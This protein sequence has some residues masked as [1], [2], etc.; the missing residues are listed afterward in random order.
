[1]GRIF[2]KRKH[3]MFARFDRMAKQFTR[4][5][6]EI[7]IAVKQGGPMPENNPKLRTVI[8]N[9]KAVNMPKDRVDAA[10]KRASSKGDSEN[11]E[12]VRFE[13][14]AP[15][16]VAVL[17]ETATDNNTRTVA[18]VR[19][20]FNKGGGAMGKTGSLDFIFTRK[21]VLKIEKSKLGGRDLDEFEF[22][23]IDFGL[24]EVAFD[25]EMVYVYCD[26]TSFGQMQKALEDMGIEVNTA[27]L[28]YIPNTWV[29]L[30][31]E[32]AKEVLDLVDRLEGDDDVQ[33]VY[34]NLR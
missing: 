15:H 14:Y 12:E 6:K 13:G 8:Q 2:E 25:D 29:D 23:L 28:Q 16:G 31:E 21:G 4:I 17:V 1:M 5:G 7:A 11:Y 3:T 27:E 10:I 33:T 9:A 20:H 24:D 26:F 18:N 19:M 30:T 34:H 32:Q 22:E